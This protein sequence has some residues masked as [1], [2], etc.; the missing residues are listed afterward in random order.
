MKKMKRLSIHFTVVLL[1]IPLINISNA[2]GSYVGIQ[3]CNEFEWALS[4][5]RDNWDTYDSDDLETTLENII[6]LGESNLTRVFND[7]SSLT[8]PQSY[9][10]II[11][12]NPGS[13]QTDLLLSPNDN[14]SITFTA[15]N[16]TFGWLIPLSSSDEWE[17]TWY[18]VNDTSS[19]LRQTLNLSLFFSPYAMFSVLFAPKTINWSLLVS[20]FLRVMNSR[21]GLYK[22]ISATAQSNGFIVNIPALGFQNN[23]ATIEI[24]VTYS[25]NGVL[26]FY[27]FSYGAQRL[28]VFKAGA[29]IPEQERVPNQYVYVFI[30]LI[31]I[32]VVEI[33]IYIYLRKGRRI[34]S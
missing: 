10:Y 21:G 24:K 32:L 16:G 12:I 8:P 1:L 15:V 19:F 7:W 25:M 31:S 23:S 9:W 18:I 4:V 28:A 22:N 27:E 14:T 29:Y 3:N 6:S 5:H 2:Q 33:F 20:D 17:D 34:K 30:G 13:E 11:S 26:S